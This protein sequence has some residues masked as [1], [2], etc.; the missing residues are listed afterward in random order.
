VRSFSKI[1]RVEVNGQ[2]TEDGL[3]GAHEEVY[4]L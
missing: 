4:I 2:S 1:S 3:K